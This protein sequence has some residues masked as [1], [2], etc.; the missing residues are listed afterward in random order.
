MMLSRVGTRQSIG[1]A[2]TLH[3]EKTEIR[4]I[5]GA[6]ALGCWLGYCLKMTIFLLDCLDC[7]CCKCRHDK[8]A[9]PKP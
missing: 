7:C 6:A 1:D 5:P 8:I 9:L 4:R 3:W 2:N